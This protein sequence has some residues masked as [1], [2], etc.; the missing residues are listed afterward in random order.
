MQTNTVIVTNNNLVPEQ[1][2]CFCQSNTDAEPPE[3]NMQ[4]IDYN[5]FTE[6]EKTQINECRTMILSKLP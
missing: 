5:D 2:V 6:A 3:D 4:K 1:Q